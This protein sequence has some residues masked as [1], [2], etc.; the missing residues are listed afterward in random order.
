MICSRNKAEKE[1]KS[2]NNQ[3]QQNQDE[4]STDENGIQVNC[5]EN[6]EENKR[7]EK[8]A[9]RSSTGQE[10]D[11]IQDISKEKQIKQLEANP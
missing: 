8:D 2:R 1:K 10:Q 11:C 6:K 7:E 9:C 5:R 4:D 3:Q